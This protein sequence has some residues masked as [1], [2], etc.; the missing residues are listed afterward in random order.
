MRR[1]TNRFV[2]LGVAI[3]WTVLAAICIS[4][5]LGFNQNTQENADQSIERAFSMPADRVVHGLDVQPDAATG[6]LFFESI[7]CP[8]LHTTGCVDLG[9]LAQRTEGA[10][11]MGKNRLGFLSTYRI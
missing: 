2:A 6:T 7:A 9:L 11:P 3:V 4:E 5:Q 1:R 8:P 10:P